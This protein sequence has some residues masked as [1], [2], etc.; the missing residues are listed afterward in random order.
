[1]DGD[2]DDLLSSLSLL[3]VDDGDWETVLGKA[4]SAR[5]LVLLPVSHDRQHSRLL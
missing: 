5:C 2:D 4:Q 1:M 3:L